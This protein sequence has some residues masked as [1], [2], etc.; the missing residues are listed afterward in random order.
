MCAHS[1]G[2]KTRKL[3]SGSFME[4]WCS[5]VRVEGLGFQA[6]ASLRFRVRG[7]RCFKVRDKTREEKPKVMLCGNMPGLLHT[8]LVL[9]ADAQRGGIP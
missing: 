4:V 3:A 8:L 9:T 6:I 2:A 5:R 7:P 1:G